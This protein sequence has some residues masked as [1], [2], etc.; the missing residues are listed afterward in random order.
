MVLV[1][2]AVAA[3]ADCTLTA[4]AATADPGAEHPTGLL[5][6][7]AT[8]GAIGGAAARLEADTPTSP[9]D[10]IVPFTVSWKFLLFLFL[11]ALSAG[12]SILCP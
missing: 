6:V 12:V 1:I 8:S 4:G 7:I 9:T 11:S 5:L 3:T 10:A 2:A